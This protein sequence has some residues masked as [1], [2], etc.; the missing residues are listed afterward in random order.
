[1]NNV[2]PQRNKTGN[3]IGA[4]G[5]RTLSEALKVNTALTTLHLGREQ[6]QSNTKHEHD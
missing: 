3:W 1:M 4:K 6:Q 5:A 2:T